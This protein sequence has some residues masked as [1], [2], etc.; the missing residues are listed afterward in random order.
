M[1]KKIDFETI[2][3]NDAIPQLSKVVSQEKINKWAGV[4]EDFNPLHVDPEYAKKT[5]FKR[6]IAHGPLIISFISEMMGSW[7]GADWLEGGKL[8][9]I[10]FKAPVKSEDQITI[11]GTVKNKTIV[12]DK[13]LLECEVFITNQEGIK[14][15]EGKAIAPI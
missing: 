12:E 14:V 5:K 13:K 15:L 3:L 8:L 1:S 11:E 7:L 10:R 4:V 9:D 2:N 6:T